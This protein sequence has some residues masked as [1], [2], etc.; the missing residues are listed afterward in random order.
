M[1]D[2]RT[3]AA[4][5]P[6]RRPMLGLL[7]SQSLGAFNDNAWKQVV[8]LL[9]VAAAS[10]EAAA[11]GQAAFAQVV[12][13]IPLML[14][15]L[16]AGVL[17]DRV[18]KRTVILAMKV[19]EVGL[20]LAGTVCLYYVP[21][22]GVPALAVLGWLGVQAALFSPAK[23]GIL[24]EILPHERLSSGNGLL[25]MCTNLAIIAGTVAGGVIVTL[26]GGRPWLGG[27]LLS[28]LSVVGLVAAFGV[29]RV[30]VARSEGGLL[31]TV[32]IARDAIRGD[33]ILRLAIRGQVFVWTIASL[34][35]APLL[36]YSSKVLGLEAWT[37]GLPLAALGVG[38]GLGCVA[39]G[40]ISAAKVEYGLL[41]LGALGL[42]VTTCAFAALSPGV[43]GTIAIMGLI[44]F[45]SGLLFV[46][47]NALIQWRSPVDRRG[48][49]IAVA[50]VLVFGGM[51]AGS[52]LAM[53]TAKLG[54]TPQNTFLGASA[55]LAVGFAWAFWLV[56][57]AFLRFLLVLA[58]QTVYRVRVVGVGN[59]PAEG[60]ALLAPNHVSFV[61]GLF[62]IAS[63]DRPVRFVVYAEYFRRPLLG[64][65][66]RSMRAIPI[67]SAGGPKMILQ[68]FREAGKALDSGELVCLFPEGQITR[69]GTTQPF[70]RG[71]ERIVK[72]R[73][74]PIVPVHIDRASSSIFSPL[75]ARRLPERLPLPVTVSFG[76]P[77]PTNT[78][79][80][81]IRRAIHELG[82]EAWAWRKQDSRPLHQEF[83]RRA[84]RSPFRL[85]VVDSST[86]GLSRIGA[87]ASALALARALKPRWAGQDAVGILLPTGVAATL[88]N[89]AAAVAGRGSVN[90]NYTAGAGE[91]ESAS[92][93][94]GLQSVL[95]SR[96]FFEKGKVALPEGTAPIWIEDL[97]SGLRRT[98]RLAALAAACFAP[99][100]WLEHYAGSSRRTT[101]DDV[102]TIIFSSGNTGD[103]RGV[104]LTHD[105][106]GSNAEA[107]AQVFRWRPDDRILDVLPPFH[108]FGYLTLWLG[109]TRGLP[110]VCHANP[111]EAATVGDLVERYQATIL[112]ATPMFLRVYLR[113]CPPAQLG[114]L[115]LVVVG[116]EK[117]SEPLARAFEDA[118]GVRP[119]EGYGMT[120][121]SPVVAVSTPDYRAPGFFQPGSR[122][123]FVGQPLPGVTVRVVAED[124][125]VPVGP[126]VAGVIQV[127]GPNVMRGYLGRND[128]TATAVRE[129]WYV[130]GDVG[131]LDE[132]GFLKVLGR[133]SRISRIDGGLVPHERL[134]EALHEVI[135]SEERVFAVTAVDGEGLGER[136][137]VLH[138][139]DDATVSRALQGLPVLGLPNP[140]IPRRDQFI[141][142]D[143][144]LY[145]P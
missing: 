110:L 140:L 130:S 53:A 15:S 76:A 30:P 82:G 10:S 91:M 9:A 18:S 2:G 73:S 100:R 6:R 139:V 75:S 7:V 136:L 60:G 34:V 106:V 118:F 25:E 13:M 46:P 90:L 47:L 112:P 126:T 96:E 17:A 88:A 19:F 14:V 108:S 104:I 11:Q 23:Y 20:M 134:E 66:L 27:V 121:C 79:L 54:L 142:V 133:L 16:P 116:G 4:V 24:P 114:S 51:L 83:I 3:T 128:L 29:P 39:A 107:V 89:L 52:V 26:T 74:V 68:A 40:R 135:G 123:G 72:G 71:L 84:R 65:F 8:V 44:G 101:V 12:L 122:R 95:T 119:L 141:R 62:V 103:P 94:A 64:V 137:V 22:G 67:S 45:A 124:T 117:L 143:A 132:D 37:T 87:L 127:K 49:V 105:N 102:A 33:R 42:S 111:V 28:V 85:A 98:D 78:P 109:L 57:D 32:R 92:R 131:L 138:T 35:P 31:T 144:F 125:G 41:P 86:P 70:Q 113:R 99:T 56:P 21:S 43:V 80:H 50:N 115:R 1:K 120:E 58:A 61:D 5:A 63:T 81:A 77:L 38:I 55:V 93:Q 59:V 145:F 129:G 36:S 48:A 97:A 69:T